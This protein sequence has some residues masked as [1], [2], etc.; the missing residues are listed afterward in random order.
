[1][2]WIGDNNSEWGIF[3]GRA[4]WSI[5]LVLSGEKDF[6]RETEQPHSVTPNYGFVKTV[7][8]TA[9]P[10]EHP[11]KNNRW[12][13]KSLYRVTNFLHDSE[14]HPPPGKPFCE[15]EKLPFL[16]LKASF[17]SESNASIV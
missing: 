11:K 16:P 10:L 13:Q 5:N 15:S 17:L 6:G 3:R 8:T 9:T 2:L 4:I 7:K 14:E 1:M 12:R